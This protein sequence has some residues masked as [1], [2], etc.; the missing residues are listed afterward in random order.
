[1]LT[2]ILIL[3]SYS[4][5][6]EFGFSDNDNFYQN[7]LSKNQRYYYDKTVEDENLYLN[8]PRPNRVLRD[9]YEL[10]NYNVSPILEI[11]NFGIIKFSSKIGQ[12]FLSIIIF[13]TFDL[14]KKFL[15]WS[16]L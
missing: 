6:E 5:K 1:M 7:L 11:L 8:C 14:Y 3:I 9:V 13:L 12:E 4:I 2:L 15:I 10:M 16:S